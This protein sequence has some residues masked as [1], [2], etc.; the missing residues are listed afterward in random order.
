MNSISQ[1]AASQ[2]IHELEHASGVTFF[3]RATR[4]LVVTEAGR[5]YLEMCRDILR[6]YEQ[7]EADLDQLKARVAGHVAVASIY[8]VGLSELSQLEQ[9]FKRRHPEA[10]VDVRIPAP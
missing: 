3:D 5:L 7:F 4:P 8:S 10:V 2:H 9:E 1:S 6:R